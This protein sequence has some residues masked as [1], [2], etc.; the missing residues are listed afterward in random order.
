[1]KRQSKFRWFGILAVTMAFGAGPASLA[2]DQSGNGGH[3]CVT[4]DS[5]GKLTAKLF[6][7]SV[8]I[9]RGVDFGTAKTVA[10]QV[11]MGVMRLSRLSENFSKSVAVH[12]QVLLRSLDPRT[13]DPVNTPEVYYT[14][15]PLEFIPDARA[16]ELC[17]EGSTKEQLAIRLGASASS[18]YEGALYQIKRQLFEAL[19]IEHRAGLILHEA[20]YR[21]LAVEFHHRDSQQARILNRWAASPELGTAS[22]ER[23]MKILEDAQLLRS[24]YFSTLHLSPISARVRVGDQTCNVGS[25]ENQAAKARYV[26]TNFGYDQA[27]S[28]PAYKVHCQFSLLPGRYEY[29][30]ELWA[31]DLDGDVGG[32]SGS[33]ARRNKPYVRYWYLG[34]ANLITDGKTRNALERLWWYDPR[35][36]NVYG[37]NGQIADFRIPLEGKGDTYIDTGVVDWDLPYLP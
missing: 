7:Y 35:K 24:F 9:N 22:K 19:P 13:G 6:D 37:L 25:A 1:M 14:L 2:Q 12:A 3:A 29:R 4:L 23:L 11:Q 26:L 5:S 34:N 16:T 10:E 8:G 33:R 30:I 36:G 21:Y 31:D 28:G 32:R 20:I 17:P 18:E 15:N 27:E